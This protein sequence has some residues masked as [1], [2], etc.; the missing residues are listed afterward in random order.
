MAESAVQSPY[1]RS[2]ALDDDSMLGRVLENRYRVDRV[3]GH[4]GMATVYEGVDLRLHRSVAI[5]VMLAHLSADAG[6]R[7]RFVREARTAASLTN[8]HIVAV[9][10]QGEDAG[11]VFLVM[12]L[13]P[14]RSLR[15]VLQAE[16]SLSV[17]AT[18][19]TLHAIGTGLAAAH[20]A[21]LV[22]RDVK[23]ENILV[24]DD[25]VI[26]VADFGLARAVSASSAT[27]TGEIFGTVAYLSPEQVETGAA[28]ARSDVYAA[29]LVLV[30]MLTGAK[31]FAGETAI[32]V[33]YQHVHGGG[34]PLPTQ[35][36]SRLSPALDEL[37]TALTARNRQDRPRDAAGMV[38]LI[39][40][41]RSRLTTE[42]LATRARVVKAAVATLSPLA[43]PPGGSP[44][45]AVLPAGG[46]LVVAPAT[47]AYAPVLH[48]EPGPLP[49]P[50]RR[51]RGVL[52]WLFAL[53][54]LAGA[55][56][57][58]FFLL[59]PGSQTVVPS[60][61]NLTVAQATATLTAG[62][63]RPAPTEVYSESVPPGEVVGTDPAAG[64]SVRKGS[65]VALLISRGPER[66]AV[67]TVRG[68]TPPAARAALEAGNLTVGTVSEAFDEAIPAG[69]VISSDPAAGTPLRP[70]APV[71][72]VVS[73][74][75]QPVTLANWTGKASADA[76]AAFTKV[77]LKATVTEEF[78]EKVAKGIVISQDPTKGPLFKGDTVTLV[79]SK[80]P[81]LV[82]VP[83]VV[84]LQTQQARR[85]L[86]QA[87]FTVNIDRVLGG[88]FNT[89][90]DQSVPAGTMAP[91]GT[92]ITL[93]VV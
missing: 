27:A 8:P 35:R 78:S 37:V 75:R 82:E 13:V 34:V 53:G 15:E 61:K 18:L 19:D 73:K 55:A 29:G 1:T 24:R 65:R 49:Q 50:R 28:D 33:A 62:E 93:T 36:D 83:N 87:G 25:G 74:G 12:E 17:E 88:Y 3:I 85:I 42:E 63:V 9:H 86:Q 31:A 21:G 46:A 77:G 91:K 10:D 70:D 16:G 64:Q 6:F 84:S 52:G 4:G 38:E 54:V 14:G 71:A 45:T 92:T 39:E 47:T 44:A 72:L 67:P 48:G 7:S 58:W 80:G 90:R 41:T 26:K 22:H 32:Q 2:V 60:V 79:V 57:G 51:R 56:A 76:L 59:G 20:H 5:K 11:Q 66:Y 30:E 89:V 43:E 81:P 68:L 23:P 69:Q 40:W